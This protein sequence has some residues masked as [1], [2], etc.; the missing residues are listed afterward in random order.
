MLK[1]FPQVPWIKEAPIVASMNLSFSINA[2]VN[3]LEHIASTKSSR[4]TAENWVLESPV[5]ITDITSKGT[6]KL[7]T[8]LNI[9]DPGIV[10]GSLLSSWCKLFSAS[11]IIFI[12]CL[13]TTPLLLGPWTNKFFVL[14]SSK[15]PLTVC[16]KKKI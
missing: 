11:S 9:T 15:D 5:T 14:E 3:S 2:L 8:Q 12:N 6:S 1:C 7:S 4:F 13:F 10:V 16:S